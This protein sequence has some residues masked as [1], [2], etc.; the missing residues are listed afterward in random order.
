M[1][2]RRVA[3]PILTTNDEQKLVQIVSPVGEIQLK[4]ERQTSIS[5][6]SSPLATITALNRPESL[7]YS[8]VSSQMSD[9]SW[10]ISEFSEGDDDGEGI[11]SQDWFALAGELKEIHIGNKPERIFSRIHSLTMSEIVEFES[12]YHGQK[13]SN[14]F[15]TKNDVEELTTNLANDIATTAFKDVNNAD[16]AEIAL[17]ELQ[18]A[19]ND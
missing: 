16:S 13:F 4:A 6:R 2:T 19:Y 12:A 8:R 1:S 3:K 15:D 17:R 18:T 11:D 5:P 9:F 14:P 7:K 10:T